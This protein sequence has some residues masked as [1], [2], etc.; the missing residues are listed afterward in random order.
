MKKLFIQ[1][2]LITGV[3]CSLFAQKTIDENKICEPENKEY[4]FSV[5]PV[6]SF[7][8][9]LTLELKITEAFDTYKS[10]HKKFNYTETFKNETSIIQ[11]APKVA[12][13]VSVARV[14]LRGEKY[15]LSTMTYYL[16][17]GK[18]WES[19]STS[20]SWTKMRLGSKTSSSSYNG[21]GYKGELTIK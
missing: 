14:E 9:S 20:S 12:I 8:D 2:L 18:C 16:K 7:K 1:L 6:E 4:D 5:K 15:Y 17:K 11:I 10:Y 19:I 13:Q 21:V 3:T